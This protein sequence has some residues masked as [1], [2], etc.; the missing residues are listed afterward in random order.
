[1]DR[2][3]SANGAR[4]SR[5]YEKRLGALAGGLFFLLLPT[6]LF[7]A[8]LMGVVLGIVPIA[9]GA[10]LE[11]LRPFYIV[12]SLIATF[13]GSGWISLRFHRWLRRRF[14]GEHER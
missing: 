1:M 12:L 13:V 5:K 9:C 3:G 6:L 7:V 10:P 2:G 14:A 11:E 8:L 4:E